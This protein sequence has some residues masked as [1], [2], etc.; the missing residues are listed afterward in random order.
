MIQQYIHSITKEE[1]STLPVEEFPGRIIV[2][3]TLKDTEKA[4]FYLSQFNKV[5]FVIRNCS[6]IFLPSADK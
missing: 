6:Q 3:D 4:L 1:I 2:I 5:G